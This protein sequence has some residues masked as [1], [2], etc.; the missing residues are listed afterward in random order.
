MPLDP[1]I[2]LAG[3]PPAPQGFTPNSLAQ[4][5]QMRQA[6]QE[7]KTQ[8]AMQNALAA[9]YSNP[10]NFG[11][12]GM[13]N[14][15]A[16]QNI[17]RVAPQAAQQLI[18]QKAALEEKRA[19]TAKDQAEAGL[20]AQKNIQALVR[21]PA[22]NAYDQALAAGKAPQEAQRIAQKVY[23][24]GMEQLS[25][26]GSIPDLMKS[27]L[28]QA[29]DPVQV[30][31][32]SLTYKQAQD[33]NQKKEAQQM[34]EAYEGAQL[35]LG[36]ERIGLESAGIGI[37]EQELGLAKAR[38][39]RAE[40]AEADASAGLSEDALTDAAWQQI[41]TGTRAIQGY[42]KQAVAQRAAVQNQIAKIAKD[43]GVS[44]QELATTSGRNKA[45][46]A[47]LT[48]LQ[49]QSDAMARSEQSFLNNAQVLTDMSQKLTRSGVPV[50]DAWLNAGKKSTG[51]PDVAAFD[52]ALRTASA[53]YARIMGGQ[54]GAAG[55]PV[56]TQ[57]E[58]ME[59][60]GKAPSPQQLQA[61]LGVMNRDIA[62]QQKAVQDQR[63]V[64]LSNMQEFGTS[65]PSGS[66]S[67]PKTV[68]W[69]D[70]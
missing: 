27:Q 17:G 5:M 31:A 62:G 63:N 43:A 8:Q 15:E 55:T 51:D 10:A 70:L 35:Q 28:P 36:K 46:Q 4:I 39:A 52:T 59:M 67:Q 54:T 38:E 19:L 34:R 68:N 32:T 45:F 29:F 14:A 6:N 23:S 33:L 61:I 18:S 60:F 26:S 48:N 47:S 9:I 3:A 64:I 58:A 1:S 66:S 41:L 57:A 49:K 16:I 56:S 20:A 30:R 7:F 21:D 13:P 24:E 40:K 2:I 11:P 25:Q 44:P 22:L 42:G 12:D 69:D 53:D 50:I 37:R 65:K